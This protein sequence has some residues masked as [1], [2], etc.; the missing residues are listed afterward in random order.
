MPH[1]DWNESYLSA[2]PPPWDT[3]SVEPQLLELWNA[4]RLPRG[5]ALEVGCDTGTNAVWLAQQGYDVVAVDIAP[6]AIERA[7]RRAAAANVRCRFAALDFLSD[8]IDERPFDLV[9]D[10]GCFHV[11]DTPQEQRRFAERVAGLLAPKGLWVSLIGS[12]EG[13]PREMGPPRRSARDVVNAIEPSLEI[14]ELS[15]THFELG[16]LGNPAAWRCISA[17][18]EVPAQPSTAD[19]MDGPR[20]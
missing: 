8:R 9:F 13:G 18:R 20:T 11:F 3:G 10:L 7:R 14:R 6:A 19:R 12:T 2:A 16:P 15:A 5:R 1:P 17:R 4:Q